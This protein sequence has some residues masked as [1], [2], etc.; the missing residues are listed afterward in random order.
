MIFC[1]W[2]TGRTVVLL[3][4]FWRF[5]WARSPSA[6][7][8]WVIVFWPCVIISLTQSW[9]RLSPLPSYPGKVYSQSQISL[10]LTLGHW[11]SELKIQGSGNALCYNN[12]FLVLLR[13]SCQASSGLEL[14]FTFFW[15][16]EKSSNT[17]PG[18]QIFFFFAVSFKFYGELTWKP[19][20]QFSYLARN[21][22]S[23]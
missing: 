13:L 5:Y 11:R 4:Y 16:L 2:K 20:G 10:C 7:L 12:L 19:T 1:T 23:I 14:P 8:V 6:I 18:F 15:T 22:I 17:I 9:E 3:F 21:L